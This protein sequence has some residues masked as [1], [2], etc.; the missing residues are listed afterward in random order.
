[1]S[2]AVAIVILANFAHN[3]EKIIGETSIKTVIIT[4]VGDLLG[5]FKKVLTNF[6]VKKVK[7]M[8]PAYNLPG[9]IPF[10]QAM[11]AGK[12]KTFTPVNIKSTD[13]AFLQYTG[14]TTGLSKGAELTHRNVLYNVWQVEPLLNNTLKGPLA[15]GDIAIIP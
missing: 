10:T 1:D 3:L 12:T 2:G 15:K 4:Q 14:G 6:V 8:V 9:A 7:K 5:G 11:A 13:T